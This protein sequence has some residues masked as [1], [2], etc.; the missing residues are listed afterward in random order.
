MIMVTQGRSIL[1]VAVKTLSP[2]LLVDDD[3]NDVLLMQ[4][5]FRV[6]EVENPLLV[7]GNGEVAIALLS[8]NDPGGHP[9]LLITDIKMPRVDGFELLLWLQTQVHLREIPKLVIS[10]SVLE[11]DLAKSL[12]L[13]ATGYF[14]KPTGMG[15][16]VGLVRRWKGTY[17]EQR[18]AGRSLRV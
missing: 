13:G 14:T 3:D 18:R 15:A 17:L 2:V 1:D 7:A 4:R 9:C 10:S 5:A 6:A 16:L 11:E 12:Q 8:G